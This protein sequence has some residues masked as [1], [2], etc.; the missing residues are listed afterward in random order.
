[1]N[2]FHLRRSPTEAKENSAKRDSIEKMIAAAL[3]AFPDLT[4]VGFATR[5][6]EKLNPLEVDTAL[7]FLQSCGHTKQAKYSSY[8]LKHCVE[9]WGA[10]YGLAPYVTNGALIVAAHALGFVIKRH[11]D[12]PN[13][14]IG[15]TARSLKRMK[16]TA[17]RPLQDAQERRRK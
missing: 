16:Q 8:F 14:G 2:A 15:V 3:A 7:S 10:A 5:C 11:G 9:D 1:M 4:P 13:A 17:R 12:S 6:S